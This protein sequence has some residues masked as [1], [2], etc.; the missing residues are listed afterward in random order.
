[1][2]CSKDAAQPIPTVFNVGLDS[3][4]RFEILIVFCED[5]EYDIIICEDMFFIVY[6]FL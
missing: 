2:L 4:T 3:K 5:R 1:M 6:L